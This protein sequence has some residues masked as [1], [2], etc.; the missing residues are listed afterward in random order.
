MQ[1]RHASV[2]H[3]GFT[4]LE[5]LLAISISVV[6]SAGAYQV[7]AA[8]AEALSTVKRIQSKL[9]P[10]QDLQWSLRHD[11]HGIVR[12]PATNDRSQLS[13]LHLKSGKQLS[14]FIPGPSR[15][16]FLMF[17]ET[18]TMYRSKTGEGPAS[19]L[20]RTK[21]YNDLGIRDRNDAFG[22][23]GISLIKITQGQDNSASPNQLP[24]SLQ[25]TV[26]DI[27]LGKVTLE[28]GVR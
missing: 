21:V 20:E 11:L 14:L 7:L 23:G 6:I 19:T 4:L 18:A 22:F 12:V 26:E 27:E 8:S 17:D 9:Q 25:I 10:L 13:A 16:S 5:L 28:F 1:Q 2:Q 15:T 3:G 24:S